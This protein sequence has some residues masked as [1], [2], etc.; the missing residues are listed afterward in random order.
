[1]LQIV[2][3]IFPALRLHMSFRV[4]GRTDAEISL[5]FNLSDELTCIPVLIGKG[6][7]GRFRDISPKSQNILDILLLKLTDY[8]MDVRPCR[9]NTCQMGK[10]CHP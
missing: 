5:L 6:K 7:L 9:R 3:I 8:L 1:M 4:A 2:N 10:A